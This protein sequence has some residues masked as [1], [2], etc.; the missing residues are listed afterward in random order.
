MTDTP[1]L[2]CACTFCT[3]APPHVLRQI[4]SRGDAEQRS[5][6][7]RTLATT[8]TLRQA[9][10]QAVAVGAPP[11]AA[12]AMAAGARPAGARSTH[13]AGGT[14]DLPGNRFR[15]EGAGPVGDDA[16]DEAH[17]FAGLTRDF[18]SKVFRRRSIDGRGLALVSTVHFDKDY[19]NAFWDGA[20][21]V[22]GDGDGKVFNRFT[23]ALEV[24]G[25][26]LAHGV[27]QYT[28][29]LIYFEQ[30]GALNEHFSDVIG[31]LVKQWHLGQDA[32]QA[33][34]LIGAGLL[35]PGIH[36][37]ALRS[38]SAPGTAYDD[39]LIGRDPQPTHMRDYHFGPEDQ[40]G[41][42][43]NSGIPNRVFWRVATTLGG[44]AWK[45]AGRIWWDAFT[46]MLNARAT[47]SDAA[48]ATIAAAGEVGGQDA[49]RAVRAAWAEAGV[50][51]PRSTPRPLLPTAVVAAGPKVVRI[52]AHAGNAMA[53]AVLAARPRAA[54]KRPR[55]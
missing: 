21:M 37:S 23:V 48:R 14:R 6:A 3:I 43:I 53:G 50:T 41:V 13:D 17:D 22:Y 32:G 31:S 34:W 36:G 26:E 10:L 38:M 15:A 30:P 16:V 33:D 55:G 45:T 12:A 51:V 35:A 4:A 49:L 20:Q 28:S 25:H 47:F 52:R 5:S 8:R 29:N 19:D 54:E 1:R 46:G 9:R 24:V 39:P 42:H 44:P 7:E 2:A 11:P 40:G 18:L 27:T